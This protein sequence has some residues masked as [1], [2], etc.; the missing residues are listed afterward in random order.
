MES[1]SSINPGSQVSEEVQVQTCYIGSSASAIDVMWEQ[2]E[3]LSTHA[4][5]SC[6]PGCS[7]CQRWEKVKS[8]LLQ[9]FN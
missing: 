5:H 7:E 1:I 2:L 8:F 6:K 4:G 3:F 9:P